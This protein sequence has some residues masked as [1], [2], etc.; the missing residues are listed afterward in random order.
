MKKADLHIHTTAS[1]GFFSA[2]EICEKALEVELAGIAITDHDTIDGLGENELLQ[3]KFK[4]LKIVPGIEIGSYWMDL[5]LHILGYNI[6]Y[7][8]SW[9]RDY[10]HSLQKSRIE[11]IEKIISKLNKLG[12]K[13][14]FS[15]II[16]VKGETNGSIGRPHVA[17]ALVSRGY[18]PSSNEAFSS[19]LD[20]GKLAYVPRKK[21]TPFEAIEVILKAGGIPVLAHPGLSLKGSYEII[22]ELI[23]GGLLGIEVYYPEHSLD[24]IRFYNELAEQYNL[25][26]TGG[27]DFHGYEGDRL[28]KSFVDISVILQ[29][30]EKTKD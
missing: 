26:V 17:K 16:A 14:S 9:L 10:L 23:R 25:I 21:I 24:D 6:N 1:D 20:V 15:D 8:L 11:R 7:K 27:S 19:L 22:F 12:Y 28:G 4:G 5:D 18:F 3:K 29:I 13:I 30:Y 2:E